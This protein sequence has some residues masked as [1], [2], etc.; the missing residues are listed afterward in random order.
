MLFEGGM[1]VNCSVEEEV[2]V[3]VI[4]GG[5]PSPA[6][7]PRPF[8]LIVI[9]DEP[10]IAR[11]VD[12]T[13][14]EHV[15]VHGISRIESGWES[16]L[17]P[18]P[19]AI[20]L[21]YLL[22]GPLDG[23]DILRKIRS[24]APGIPVIFITGF[25]DST[26]ARQA[27][28]S[29]AVAYIPKPLNPIDLLLCLEKH[30]AGFGQSKADLSAF[31]FTKGLS[32]SNQVWGWNNSG[33][34][35]QGRLLGF[36][37]RKVIADFSTTPE[38]D[39]L[40]DF[41]IRL[42]GRQISAGRAELVSCNPGRNGTAVEI[43]LPEEWE[44]HEQYSINGGGAIEGF[45]SPESKPDSDTGLLS[46]E[47]RKA[48][49]DLDELLCRIHDELEPRQAYFLKADSRSRISLEEEF[50]ARA[51]SVLFPELS[52]KIQTFE[53]AARESI[54]NGHGNVFEA[55]AHRKLYPSLLCSPF[56]SRVIEKPIGVPGDFGMLGKILG[57]P[58][59]GAS[60]FSRFINGWILNTKAAEAYRHRVDFLERK[61]EGLGAGSGDARRRVLSIGSGVAYEIQEHLK[62]HSGYSPNEFTLVD[63]SPDTL[64]EAKACFEEIEA[65][66]GVSA[67]IHYV[68]SSV[69]SL[70]SKPHSSLES[71]G[72]GYQLAYCAGLFDYLSDRVCSRLIKHLFDQLEVGG[73]VIVSNFTPSNPIK[74]FMGL[75][76]DWKL[77][78]R[79]ADQL[80][81]IAQS[82]DLGQY[83][84]IEMM[85]DPTSVECF[86]IIR[87]GG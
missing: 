20:I 51:E 47:A 10:A 80:L 34:L 77:I 56:I 48:I 85:E 86:A 63:F 52:D 27:L 1:L 36:H 13:V 81:G 79:D 61:I 39:S 64:D 40:K 28:E 21:D 71:R 7:S 14:P 67:G 3:D 38:G 46:C 84:E 65:D 35:I 41:Q 50:V 75:V 22:R 78:H 69:K 83:A 8:S 25:G 42:G 12:A 55:Y 24:E 57:N 43:Y 53:L 66:Y 2:G 70:L 87:K 32:E 45:Q 68:E 59:E 16:V 19:D 26:I 4:L 18:A 31:S 44:S 62:R 30:V 17:D 15:S 33:D 60:L 82:A 29:G 76:L 73:E 5:Q 11:L 23:L 6:V 74:H 9:D 54:E 49:E 72:S 37:H 58:F